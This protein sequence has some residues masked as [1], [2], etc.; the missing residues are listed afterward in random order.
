MLERA[1]FSNLRGCLSSCV[2]K[3]TR[4]EFL[5]RRHSEVIPGVPRMVNEI[6]RAQIVTLETLPHCRWARSVLGMNATRLVRLDRRRTWE[7]GESGFLLRRIY[8]DPNDN[9]YRDENRSVTITPE[10][11]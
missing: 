4:E 3:G 10:L 5:Q 1:R 8:P 9:F 2:D 6:R 11:K 7:H